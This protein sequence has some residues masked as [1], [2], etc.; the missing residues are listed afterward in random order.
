ML[1]P[2]SYTHLDVYK[3]Q[4]QIRLVLSDKTLDVYK[5]RNAT[6]NAWKDVWCE[7]N[8]DF[9]DMEDKEKN[10]LGD[11]SH[12][13]IVMSSITTYVHMSTIISL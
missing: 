1:I 11:F 5:Y 7:L 8:K 6:G 2:V 3:R 10:E 13:L 9:E 4:V 12:T